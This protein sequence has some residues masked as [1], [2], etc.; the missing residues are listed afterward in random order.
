MIRRALTAED[1]G[2][3]HRAAA[4]LREHYDQSVDVEPTR[5]RPIEYYERIVDWAGRERAAV[6]TV[7]RPGFDPGAFSLTL[8]TERSPMTAFRFAELAEQGYYNQRRIDT[9]VPGLRVHTG[10]G[11]ENNYAADSWRAEAVVSTFPAGTLAAV[12]DGP[13]TL[14]GEWM[15]TM[16]SRPNYLGRYWPF[17]RVTRS[18][19]GVVGNILPIDRVISVRVYEGNGLE[20]QMPSR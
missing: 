5:P 17:G 4:L 12:A 14:L 11:G 6:V 20:A 16:D 18:L 3:R 10:R 1:T 13:E 8:D 9:F 2:I 19:G 15:I 7:Y